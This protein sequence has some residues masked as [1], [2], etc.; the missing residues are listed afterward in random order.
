MGWLCGS[1]SMR[2]HARACTNLLTH[3]HTHTHTHT[4]AL[5]HTFTHTPVTLFPQASLLLGLTLPP[6]GIWH[7]LTLS[8]KTIQKEAS[9]EST[10]QVC[11]SII[12]D[13]QAFFWVLSYI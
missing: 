10:T 9:W 13:H 1:V 6:P 3:T 12:K 8:H 4:Q 7:L 2:V 5:T 11:I